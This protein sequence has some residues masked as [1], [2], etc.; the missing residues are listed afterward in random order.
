MHSP[1]IKFCPTFRS[2][3]LCLIV[4]ATIICLDDVFLLKAMTGVALNI[5]PNL[6][7]IFNICQCLFITYR[8][9]GKVGLYVTD[10][11][12]AF[13]VTA[14]VMINRVDLSR[15]ST[16]S[17]WFQI[18]FSLYPFSMNRLTKSFH[19]CFFYSSKVEQTPSFLIPN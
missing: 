17:I 8:I 6:L 16:F 19:S 2:F 11:G 15:L 10:D 12:I 7:L 1:L 18:M 5:F 3:W 9:F 13:F 14:L 4:L